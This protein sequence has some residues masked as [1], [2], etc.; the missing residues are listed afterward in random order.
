MRVIHYPGQ[1]LPAGARTAVT[2]GKFQGV[3]RGHQAVLRALR[4][5]AGTR[6][7]TPAVVTFDRHPL[8][9]IAPEH[10][11]APLV[12]ADE[13]LR[14][15]ESAGLDA[16]CIL[17]FDREMMSTPPDEFVRRVIVDTMRA[18]LV[19]VGADFRF[20]ARNAGT[21]ADL[22]RLGGELG[23]EVQEVP[24]VGG[25]QKISSSGV[26]RA[27]EA[28]DVAAAAADLGRWP[29]VDGVVVHGF[30]RGRALGFPTANLGAGTDVRSGR[31]IEMSGF[32]PADGVYAGWL[33][34]A[35]EGE[36]Y[37]AAISV[38]TNPTFSGTERT[39]EAHIPGRT[40]D[41]LDLYGRA[42]S[43][44]FVARLRGMRAFG[45]VDELIAAMHADVAQAGQ[46]LA[47][48]PADGPAPV[49][50]P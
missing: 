39:V 33:V 22:R 11:P 2:I 29:A 45:S 27:L 28:G 42:V 16:V 10:C 47:M 49:A 44:R 31:D 26:R 30:Q 24:L 41:D 17:R 4:R 8:A 7:L 15:L 46:V 48:A 18:R 21:I 5:E 13:E 35:P 9:T 43:A 14:L 25:A 1:Q 20:G 12:G 3:H 37:P 36:R 6:G 34:V 40:I 23:F 32:V 50:V 19:L 38:G